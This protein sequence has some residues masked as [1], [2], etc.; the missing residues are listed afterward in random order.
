[1]LAADFTAAEFFRCTFD[2]VRT[3]PANPTHTPH[4]P[5]P[6]S[7]AHA[8]LSRTFAS[9]RLSSTLP[10]VR[11]QVEGR[12]ANFH[13]SHLRQCS[14]VRSDFTA[15]DFRESDLSGSYAATHSHNCCAHLTFSAIDAHSL[16]VARFNSLSLSLISAPFH[17]AGILAAGRRSM[18][19]I[20]ASP[21]S[22]RR[23]S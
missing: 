2:K 15:A 17:S 14:F 19:L 6:R 20:L 21:S 5:P 22:T 9:P 7:V 4:L 1:M 10:H 8:T 3:S 13:S 16:S 23:S 11:P 12:G 18:T